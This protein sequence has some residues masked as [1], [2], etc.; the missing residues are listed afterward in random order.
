MNPSDLI[1]QLIFEGGAIVSSN[2]C[3]PTE[4]AIARTENRF[5]VD[6]EGIGFVRRTK[7]WLAAHSGQ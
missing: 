5:A 6:T 3:S 4:I 7:E 2:E 1:T